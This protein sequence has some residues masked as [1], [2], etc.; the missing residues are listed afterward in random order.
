LPERVSIIADLSKEELDKL[1]D[2]RKM[3]EDG[4]E[5]K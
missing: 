3:T 1:L 2:P 4:V 5:G